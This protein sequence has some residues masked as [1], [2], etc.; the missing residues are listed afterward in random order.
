MHFFILG[1]REVK[2]ADTITRELVN[3]LPA[4]AVSLLFLIFLDLFHALEELLCSIGSSCHSLPTSVSLVA[5]M[6]LQSLCGELTIVTSFT[7][8]NLFR[9]SPLLIKIQCSATF[10]EC[11]SFWH[12]CDMLCLL[13][14]IHFLLCNW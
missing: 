13:P 2:L 9:A 6:C 1:I 12:S 7:V 11:P 10:Q 8:W 4:T 5:W 3:I 14:F